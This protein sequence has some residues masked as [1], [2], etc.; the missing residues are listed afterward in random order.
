M[1]ENETYGELFRVD[2]DK[3]MDYDDDWKSSKEFLSECVVSEDQVLRIEV[4]HQLKFTKGRYV[5]YWYRVLAY[6]NNE[7]QLMEYAS[8]KRAARKL[9]NT[10]CYNYE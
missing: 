7:L 10:L 2:C 5:P 4:R 9:F 3:V 6:E 1:L 8:G